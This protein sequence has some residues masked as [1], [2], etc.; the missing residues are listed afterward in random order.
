M[1]QTSVVGIAVA[2]SGHRLVVQAGT[3]AFTTSA[4]VCTLSLK[5]RRVLGAMVNPNQALSLTKTAKQAAYIPYVSVTQFTTATLKTRA[6][7]SRVT[8]SITGLKFSYTLIG[9]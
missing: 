2:P 5:M 4:T 1:A 9:Q 7:V 3:H 6:I 8:G